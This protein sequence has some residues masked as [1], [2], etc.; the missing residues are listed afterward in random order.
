MLQGNWRLADGTNFHVLE[1]RRTA[2]FLQL[3]SALPAAPSPLPDLKPALTVTEALLN[4]GLSVDELRQMVKDITAESHLT[5]IGVTRPLGEKWQAGA[6]VN[7]SSISSTNGAGVVPAQPN[8]GITTSYNWSLTGSNWLWT[9]NTDVININ[10]VNAPTYQGRNI[11]YNHNALL[12]GTDLRLDLGLRTYT[13]TD[14]SGGQMTRFSPTV[15]FSYRV[16]RN[17]SIEGESGSEKS[18][19]IDAQGIQVDSIRRYFYVGYRWDWQ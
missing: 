18:H 12:F 13:Q 16:R 5:N 2:P 7:W 10:T 9:N 6:D 8:S 14:T 17:V 11:S 4:T 3:S 1:D 19:Q 15:R